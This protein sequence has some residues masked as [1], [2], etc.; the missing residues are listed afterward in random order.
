MKR[1][2]P[3]TKN[4][5][6]L[7][8]FLT[9]LIVSLSTA[10]GFSR[11]TYSQADLIPFSNPELERVREEATKL[12]QKIRRTDAEMPEE[13]LVSSEARLMRPGE[14][15]K[16]KSIEGMVL[17]YLVPVLDR[18]SKTRLVICIDP[19]AKDWRWFSDWNDDREFPPVSSED[20]ALK[21]VN[22][23][24]EKGIRATL[25]SPEMVLAPD[26]TLYW[27]IKIYRKDDVRKE[28]RIFIPVLARGETIHVAD[29][30]VFENWKKISLSPERSSPASSRVYLPSRG[31][32]D[33]KEEFFARFGVKSNIQSGLKESGG[34]PSSYEI[35]DVPHYYQATSYWCGPA[36][37]QML[38]DYYGENIPQAEIAKVANS[39]PSYGVYNSD[40]LRA[41]HFSS[42]S[43]A[44][45]DSSLK[46]YTLRKRGYAASYARW[47]NGTSLYPTRYVD[48]KN[49]ISSGY[50][51]LILTDYD[52]G[53]NSGHFR[54]VKGYNDSAG[55]FTV[56]DP[57][58]AGTY[59]GPNVHFNQSFLVDNLW[60][61]SSRWGMIAAP[62]K[63]KVNK[64]SKVAAGDVFT[65]DSEIKYPGPAPLNG[66]YNVSSPSAKITAPSSD[67]VLMSG[68][69]TQPV[70]GISTTGSSGRAKWTL[71]SVKSTST[72]NIGV[73]ATGIVSGS[74]RS[75]SYYEDEIGG[76]GSGES[77]SST[78]GKSVWY[79][80]EGSTAWGFSTYISIVNPNSSRVT[81]SI[82]YM[83]ES[84]SVRGPLFS[85]APQS[86][87]TVDPSLTL[88][89]KD[90]ST[91]V[92]CVEGKTIAVDRCMIWQAPGARSPEAHSSVGVTSP[93]KIWY[94]PE[95]SSAWGFECWL[96][97]QNPNSQ[98][99]TCE[100]TYMIEGGKARVFKKQIPPN[101]RRS[102]SM[103]SDIGE[104]D[105]SIKVSSNL[106]VIA[107]RA[108]YRDSRRTG[109]GS[110]GTISP[111]NKYYLAE[112]T[113]DHGFTTYILVQNPSSD[114]A[115]VNITYMTR[116]GPLAHPGNP[117]T[118]PPLSRK[119]IRANDFI[120]P[121][122]FSTE[123][124][125]D[126]KIIAERAMYWFG[127]GGTGEACHDSIG[128]SS[129]HRIFYLPDGDT[130]GDRE[131]Y[132]L[133][134]NPNT[135]D[136]VVEVSYLTPTGKGNV[137]FQEVI[138][139]KSRRTFVMADKV[140]QG[141]AS[142]VVKSLTAG[143][144]IMVERAMYW[145]NRGAGTS[146][147]GA[148]LD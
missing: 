7:M 131:T 35:S 46:G 104:K 49:L 25:K 129:A 121:V 111:A 54:L 78:S 42:K 148:F 73:T 116:S 19:D 144:K 10:I 77:W 2:N 81:V 24:K 59:Q 58:Y 12:L 136:V 45:Q 29:L 64:P 139:A 26:K 110:I 96:L 100:I 80:A 113:T 9:A 141:R 88:G 28:E 125:S 18:N 75:Y 106:R 52:S 146:T 132:T 55:Y 43:T 8:L 127:G 83:T 130:T 69:S 65:V 99:A 79:L 137:K 114:T 38:F 31:L 40:L 101:S 5:F 3:A 67:Y 98:T 4:A 89:A 109:H 142:V 13:G 87:A 61:Y 32:P 147:V 145:N 92:Q 14:V 37:L 118:M 107:E 140:P 1:V 50:P 133:V 41:A 48:L 6:K 16:V 70:E 93:S 21:A 122:D 36:C 138:L 20:A 102:Y 90:F 76:Y 103:A 71:Q 95:G 97:I 134:Q 33:S 94:F 11:C 56:H 86:Q 84:G 30:S 82:T 68:A 44:I 39:N 123:V 47:A 91:K 66:Y 72:S 115:R 15:I 119:T 34:A 124:S 143:K 17:E 23:L 112:G 108:M 128:L 120:P 62:W 63:V 60:V 51:V 22:I 53:L 117:I 74:S 27:M 105:A 85:M 57:W 126:K 135:T